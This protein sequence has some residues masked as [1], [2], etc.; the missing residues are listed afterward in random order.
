MKNSNFFSEKLKMRKVVRLLDQQKFIVW[1]LVKKLD[2]TFLEFGDSK[3]E[4]YQTITKWCNLDKDLEDI[5]DITLLDESLRDEI[6]ATHN[7]IVYD[8]RFQAFVELR[9][10]FYETMP[11]FHI[12]LPEQ[13]QDAL[14]YDITLIDEHQFTEAEFKELENIGATTELF[15]ISDDFLE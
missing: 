4:Q 14:N 6:F 12:S 13:L 5:D 8:N 10:S 7:G 15:G 1:L 11:Q 3:S 2:S 9:D